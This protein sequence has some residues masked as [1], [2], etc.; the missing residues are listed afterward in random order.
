MQSSICPTC[1]AV[2]TPAVQGK[3][4]RCGLCILNEADGL[5]PPT[6]R[7]RRVSQ[8]EGNGLGSSWTTMTEGNPVGKVRDIQ[9]SE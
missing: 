1:K 2:M 9:R 6:D 8:R 5:P 3:D 7:F 4:K